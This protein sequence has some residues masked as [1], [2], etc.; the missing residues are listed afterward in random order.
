M[1]PYGNVPTSS[2]N[3]SG[4]LW[5][6]LRGFDFS[7]DYVLLLGDPVAIA[8]AIHVLCQKQAIREE[9]GDFATIRALKWDRRLEAYAPYEIG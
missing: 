2:E 3:T 9:T 4:A 8:R 6:A 5:Q 7:S 1:L